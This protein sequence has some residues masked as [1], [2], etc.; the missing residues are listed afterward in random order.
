MS[1]DPFFKLHPFP[2]LTVLESL[3]HNLQVI[4]G[5]DILIIFQNLSSLFHFQF[6]YDLFCSWYIFYGFLLVFFQRCF[7]FTQ[8][9][10]FEDAQRLENQLVFLV[11]TE[12]KFEA[13]A[14]LGGHFL[15]ELRS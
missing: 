12:V 14:F 10:V 11:D 2:L 6:L 9:G 4:L 5:E 3:F 1:R 7:L 15:E 13:G 8:F